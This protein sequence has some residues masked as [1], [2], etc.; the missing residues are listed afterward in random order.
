LEQEG[1]VL[2]NPSLTAFIQLPLFSLQNTTIRIRIAIGAFGC[3]RN[4]VSAL[5]L[6]AAT[7]AIFLLHTN[8]K[9]T[10]EANPTAQD[11]DSAM[12]LLLAHTHNSFSVSLERNFAFCGSVLFLPL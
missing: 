11:A 8:A 9:N 5:S 3:Y 4:P 1:S 10:F 2:Q 12:S 7:R 6:R